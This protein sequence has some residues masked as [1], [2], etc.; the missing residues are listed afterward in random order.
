MDLKIIFVATLCG[1][2]LIT[3][4]DCQQGSDN[5]IISLEI[6]ESS[7]INAG[8][9]VILDSGTQ[10]LTGNVFFTGI[11]SI[12]FRTN[13][14]NGCTLSAT[15]SSSEPGYRM[16]DP[17]QHI[18][19]KNPL[20]IEWPVETKVEGNPQLNTYALTSGVYS[21]LDPDSDTARYEYGLHK[22]VPIGFRQLV[23]SDDAYGGDYSVTVSIS[24]S[25]IP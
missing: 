1:L 21:Y 9:D 20:E 8:A 13:H 25:P 5:V 12:T 15:A 4:G 19:L 6:A 18:A 3:V 22:N 24:L 14:K 23:T 2:I 17:V 11:G 7:D 16:Y 10:S